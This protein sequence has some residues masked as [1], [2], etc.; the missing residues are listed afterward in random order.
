MP[1]LVK[2]L[3]A[4]APP[5]AGGEDEASGSGG[6]ECHELTAVHHVTNQPAVW[7]LPPGNLSRSHRDARRADA[8][9]RD[10]FAAEGGSP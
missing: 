8:I 10:C 9:S 7:P 4:G 6:G 2:A 3:S 5:H 1:S